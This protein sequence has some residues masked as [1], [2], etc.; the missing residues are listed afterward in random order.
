[1]VGSFFC[2]QVISKQKRIT[3]EEP[4]VTP[5]NA[6]FLMRAILQWEERDRDEE[7][8]EDAE[9]EKDLAEG[10]EDEEEAE[11]KEEKA[12]DDEEGEKSNESH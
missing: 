12:K 2:V 3:D 6:L 1:M 5:G 10:D 9:A 7:E 8:E 4:D 11:R